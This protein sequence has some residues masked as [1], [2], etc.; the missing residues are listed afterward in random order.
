MGSSSIQPVNS[1]LR[2]AENL[3]LDADA[4]FGL[5]VEAPAPGLTPAPFRRPLCTR[6]RK[7]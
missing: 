5:R 6:G 4:G 1:Q 3:R 2:E 7:D